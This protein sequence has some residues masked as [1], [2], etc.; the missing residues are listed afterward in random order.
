MQ[1][2]GLRHYCLVSDVIRHSIKMG[3]A[4]YVLILLWGKTNNTLKS[5]H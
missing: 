2:S 5:T 4:L 3:W 1:A